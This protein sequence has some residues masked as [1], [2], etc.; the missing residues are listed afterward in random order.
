VVH[1]RNLVDIVYHIRYVAARVAKLVRGNGF[2]AQFWRKGIEVVRGKRRW[3]QIGSIN[4]LQKLKSAPRCWR[5]L[6][7]CQPHAV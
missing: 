3:F 4:S 7:Q 2:G 5:R 6:R 1:N